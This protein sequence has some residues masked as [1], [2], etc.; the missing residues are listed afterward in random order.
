MII[1]CT[2]CWAEN[3][4]GRDTCVK[5]GASLTNDD[6]TYV[7]KLLKALQHPIPSTAVNAALVLGRR[8]EGSAVEPLIM[9]LESRDEVGVMASAAE[10]LGEIGDPK[11]VPALARLLVR[12]YLEVRL[13]AVQALAKIGSEESMK[14]IERALRDPNL[15]VRRAAQEALDAREGAHPSAA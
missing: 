15:V 1:Y 8:R 2:N 5:C 6:G 10:A 11:A 3:E 12:S 4:E 7:E 9:V 13:K 14:V